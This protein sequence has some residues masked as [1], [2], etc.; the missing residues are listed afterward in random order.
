MNLKDDILECCAYLESTKV[1][2]RKKYCNKLANYLE[3]DEVIVL[4]NSGDYVQWKKILI[5]VQECLRK[6]RHPK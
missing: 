4:I 1:T 6:V 2:E 3:K 5:S